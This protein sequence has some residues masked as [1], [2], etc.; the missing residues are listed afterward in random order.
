M[1]LTSTKVKEITERLKIEFLEKKDDSSEISIFLCGGSTKEQAKLRR[2]I[3][4]ELTGM[5]SKYTYTIHYPEDMFM[6]LIFGYKKH[7]LLSLENLLA[8]SVHVIVIILQSPGTLVELG[9][10]ANHSL[11]SDKLVVLIDSRHQRGKSFVNLGPVRYLK[12]KTKSHVSFTPLSHSNLKEIVKRVAE[13]S[14]SVYRHSTRDITLENPLASTEF[15][16]SLVHTFEPLPRYSIP[17]IVSLLGASETVITSAESII[18]TLINSGKISLKHGQ[19]S[20]SNSGKDQLLQSC[21]NYFERRKKDRFLS[22]ERCNALNLT[23]RKRKET[24]IQ[25]WESVVRV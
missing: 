4:N 21:T 20:I 8:K 5:S 3:G 25:F 13:L 10:F 19:L 12:D 1:N 6:E 7:D 23:L 14:R 2:N 9:A 16:L 15:Y 22:N 11:L 24:P 18:N 17:N